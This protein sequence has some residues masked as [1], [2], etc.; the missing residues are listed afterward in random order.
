M[1]CWQVS[2][3]SISFFK[4]LET[5]GR[6]LRSCVSQCGLR[7]VLGPLF[8]PR[9]P[10]EASLPFEAKK[11]QTMA[12]DMTSGCFN[13][14]S[15]STCFWNHLVRVCGSFAV[16]SRYSLKGSFYFQLPVSGKKLL[17]PKLINN[18]ARRDAGTLLSQS[19]H[20]TG[21]LCRASEDG[22]AGLC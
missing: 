20:I 1:W 2:E 15:G 21:D 12:S 11:A 4:F 9:D 19:P 8:S 18:P 14:L 13:T 7:L 22:T 17:R 10:A 6:A 16:S 3:C 5:D